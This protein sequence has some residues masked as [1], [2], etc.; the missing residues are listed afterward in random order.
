MRLSIDAHIYTHHGACGRD[1]P[2]ALYEE[3]Q[4]EAHAALI[5][6][7]KEILGVGVGD[8]VLDMSFWEREEREIWRGMVPEGMRVVTVYFDATED[9]LWRRIEERK[10]QAEKEGGE[11]GD[12]V[13]HLKREVL[14]GYVKGFEKPAV[15]GGEGEVIVVEVL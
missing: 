11:G 6:Q 1:Y 12:A 5:T 13:V 3:Y 10:D 2:A 15:D 8:M 7:L 9:V 14:A 4:D